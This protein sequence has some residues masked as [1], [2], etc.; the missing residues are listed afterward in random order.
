MLVSLLKVELLEWET[1]IRK[2]VRGSKIKAEDGRVFSSTKLVLAM[3]RKDIFPEIDG[4]AEN[5]P[6]HM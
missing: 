2:R 3:E 6:E 1:S 4:C 5:W